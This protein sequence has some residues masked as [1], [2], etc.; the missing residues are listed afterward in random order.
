MTPPTERTMHE[1]AAAITVSRIS[2]KDFRPEHPN[3]KPL[4]ASSSELEGTGKPSQGG[5]PRAVP[6][7]CHPNMS[8]RDEAVQPQLLAS[9][10]SHAGRTCS[11]HDR[12]P[13]PQ[14]P[15][16]A[17][18]ARRAKAGGIFLLLCRTHVCAWPLLAPG[19]PRPPRADG[20]PGLVAQAAAAIPACRLRRVETSKS[21]GARAGSARRQ[22]GSALTMLLRAAMPR[23]LA[24]S[25]PGVRALHGTNHPAVAFLAG[26]RASGDLL[27]RR[28]GGRRRGLEQRR[29]GAP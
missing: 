8:C 17:E 22:A 1:S 12:G 6:S 20:P 11:L 9:P 23:S 21:G 14:R 25:R 13:D 18:A 26:R 7:Q 24:P 15:P 16:S 10:R 3:P 19:A 29:E 28:R 5:P 4:R 27:E 2:G